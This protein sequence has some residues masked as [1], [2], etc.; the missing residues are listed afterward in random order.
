NVDHEAHLIWAGSIAEGRLDQSQPTFFVHHLASRPAAT[1]ITLR[2]RSGY[3]RERCGLDGFE[4]Y[5]SG[6]VFAGDGRATSV[7]AEVSNLIPGSTVYFRTVLEE[8]GQI[9]PGEVHSL[10]LPHDQSPSL[11]SADPLIRQNNPACY[12]VRGNAMGLE[13]EMWS[14]LTLR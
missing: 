12:L 9:L 10:T 2:I 1:S 3:H 13:T 7:S 6:A 8:D 4:V 11:E 14:E 5:G